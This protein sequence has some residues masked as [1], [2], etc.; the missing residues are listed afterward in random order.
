MFAAMRACH[1]ALA[2]PVTIAGAAHGM[3]RDNPAAFNAAVMAFLA[4]NG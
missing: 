3:Q 2:P 4:G 1:R